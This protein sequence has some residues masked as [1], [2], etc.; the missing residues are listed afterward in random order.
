MKKFT[1]EP[2]SGYVLIRRFKSNET[3]GGIQLP[4]AMAG[5]WRFYVEAF[6]PEVENLQVGDEVML[7]A[8]ER[9]PYFPL[10]DHLNQGDR[11]VVHQTTVLAV[12]KRKSN[13]EK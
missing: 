10:P 13:G 3:L 4:D 5:S 1:I 8:F 6:G 11:M 9:T 12:I 2:R 7:G